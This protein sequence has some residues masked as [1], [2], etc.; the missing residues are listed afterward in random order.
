MYLTP[1]PVIHIF[2][3]NGNHCQEQINT[4][5]IT[6]VNTIINVSP[7]LPQRQVAP[8]QAAA[9]AGEDALD[10]ASSL[11]TA[12]ES[13]VTGETTGVDELA[14]GVSDVLSILVQRLQE[15]TETTLDV[16]LSIN[17]IKANLGSLLSGVLANSN[18]DPFTSLPADNLTGSQL[19]EVD[20]G[21]RARLFSALATAGLDNG[22]LFTS[23]GTRENGSLSGIIGTPGAVS[24]DGRELLLNLLVKELNTPENDAISIISIFQEN[25][26][27]IVI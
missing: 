25:R 1:E 14:A 11:V 9:G 8:L 7:V 2:L 21:T 22:N 5:E 24:T 12:G 27:E 4:M 10:S 20:P 3:S 18:S 6:A 16:S 15:R 23:T 13:G 17:V 26:F 19:Q